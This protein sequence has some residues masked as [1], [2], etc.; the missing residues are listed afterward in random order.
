M[1]ILGI[2]ELLLSGNGDKDKELVRKIKIIQQSA[3]RIRNS[4]SRM[5]HQSRLTTKETASGSMLEHENIGTERHI[6]PGVKFS[7]KFS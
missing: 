6:R 7:K 5:E 1:T 4:L 2:S 3:R